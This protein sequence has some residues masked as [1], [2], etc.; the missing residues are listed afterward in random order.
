MSICLLLISD[1]REDYLERTL[2]SIE[3]HLPEFSHVVHIDDTHHELGFAGAIAEGWRRV[4]ETDARWVWHAEQ[5][6]VLNQRVPLSAMT[7]VM[8]EHPHLV[9]LALLRQA[10][11]AAEIA[12]GGVMQQHPGSYRAVEWN[13]YTW[14]EHRRFF[15]TNPSL[16]RAELC[17]RGWPRG[18]HSEG[19]FGLQLFNGDPT[20]RAAFW[21]DG[22]WCEHIGQVRAGQGY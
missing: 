4:R 12:A 15:T 14:H 13:G 20:L 22:E 7:S 11:N 5:D 19:M 1:G 9:Q 10:V 8:D 17:D 6:F 16:Y 2:D 21:G 3:A 18:P